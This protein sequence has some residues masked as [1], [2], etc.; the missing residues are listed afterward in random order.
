[1]SIS[2]RI[3][4]AWGIFAAH[5]MSALENHPTRAPVAIPF[6][7]DSCVP[8]RRLTMPSSEAVLRALTVTANDW[9]TLAVLWH[10]LVGA[11][12]LVIAAR[13]RLSNQLAGRLLALPLLS[14]SALAWVSWNPFNGGVFALLGLVLMRVARAM[15]AETVHTA[16]VIYLV[17]GLLLVG[18]GWVYPHFLDT[19]RW[20]DY[21]IAAPLGLLPCPTLS[22]VIGL[23]LTCSVRRS[24]RWSIP[25]A[26]VGVIYGVIGV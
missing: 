16:P 2:E 14:V 15:P 19:T 4:M 21:L 13:R 20:T 24:K 12:L 7:Q 23:T 17:P 10:V 5:D 3:R 18:F 11:L 8:R 9:R 6:R 1:M 25:L 22:A 26:A